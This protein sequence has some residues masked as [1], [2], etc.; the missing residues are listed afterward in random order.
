MTEDSKNDAEQITIPSTRFGDLTVSAESLMEFPVGLIGF[1][2]AQK[3]I[4]IEHKPPFCWL[5]SAVDPALAFV[6]VDGF[7]FGENYNVVAPYGDHTIDLQKE[8]EYAILV[9]VTVSANGM[10]TANLKAPLFVNLKNRKGIQVIFDDSRF[11]TR[12]PLWENDG[13]SDLEEPK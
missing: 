7:E 10:T 4:M 11:S 3:F 6:V 12:Y 8:D 1:P 13:E 9:I 5:Q 2:A